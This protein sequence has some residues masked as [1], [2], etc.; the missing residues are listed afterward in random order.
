M[1][2]IQSEARLHI[3]TVVVTV[4][5]THRWI[6]VYTRVNVTTTASLPS[7]DGHF[8]VLLSPGLNHMTK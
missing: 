8:P 4:V 6:E 7:M 5:L 1:D 3:G 2:E